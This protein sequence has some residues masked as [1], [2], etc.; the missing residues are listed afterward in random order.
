MKELTKEEATARIKE[1][2]PVIWQAADCGHLT[3]RVWKIDGKELCPECML[4]SMNEGGPEE[5]IGDS[6]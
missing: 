3:K 2:K 4:A 1:G 5:R 6:C